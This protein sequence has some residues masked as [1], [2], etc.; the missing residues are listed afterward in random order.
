MRKYPALVIA[1]A[2]LAAISVARADQWPAK[3]IR[4]I[5]PL[6]AGSAADIIPRIVFEQLSA[7]LGQSIIVENKPGASGTIGARTV[8]TAEPDGYTLLAHSS[9]HI[10]APSTVANLPYDP[11]KDFAAVAPLGNLPNVLVIAPS[12]NIKTLQELVAAGKQRPITF[13]SIGPGSPITLAMQRLRLSAGFKVQDIPFKGAPEALVEVMTGRVD[14]YYSPLLAALPYIKSGKLLPLAVSSPTRAPTIPNVPTTQE[15]GYANSA[16]RF[17]IGVFAPA[18]TPPDIV[19]KLNAEIQKAMQAPTVRA[20]LEKLGV[21]P[22]AMN[23]AEF[24]KFVRE[25]LQS[26]SELVKAAGIVPQ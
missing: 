24:D 22:M 16:Y 5:V 12:A 7:Q 11:I 10:I 13:G 14:V 1:L 17:W 9:A 19:K 21:Q 8:A 18:K 20:K 26:N 6:S 15:A 2:S 4:V 23:T 3:P 25:E